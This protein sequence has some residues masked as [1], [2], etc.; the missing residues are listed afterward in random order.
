MRLQLFTD[1]GELSQ[2]VVR[3]DRV[4]SV[5]LVHYRHLALHCHDPAGDAACEVAQVAN[6]LARHAVHLR[7]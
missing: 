4:G 2:A 7:H 1:S 3:S 6:V 5:S